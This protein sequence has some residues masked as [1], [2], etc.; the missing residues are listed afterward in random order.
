MRLKTTFA[1]ISV[2]VVLMQCMVDFGS[3][4]RKNKNKLCHKVSVE[5]LFLMCDVDNLMVV[6]AGH[7]RPGGGGD[8]DGE[9]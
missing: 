1:V 7:G 3:S 4:H 2:T 5:L 8:N 6:D 9:T